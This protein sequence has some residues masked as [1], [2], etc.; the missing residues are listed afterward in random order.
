MWTILEVD[1][2]ADVHLTALVAGAG[3]TAKDSASVAVPAPLSPIRSGN[4]ATKPNWQPGKTLRDGSISL[5]PQEKGGVG[6]SV[7]GLSKAHHI[8]ADSGHSNGATPD[9]RETHF[10]CEITFQ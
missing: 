7:A 5:H 8:G 4:L 3:Q 2:S 6:L 1:V 10:G 9:L